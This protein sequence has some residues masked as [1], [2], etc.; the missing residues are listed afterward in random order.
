MLRSGQSLLVHASAQ[1]GDVVVAV[2]PAQAGWEHL[3]FEARRLERGQRWGRATAESELG[4]V[5]LGGTCTIESNHG[6]WPAVGARADVFAGLPHA[7]YLPRGSE[8]AIT[9]R[10]P[11]E[12]GY[13]WCAAERTFPARLIEP[14]EIRVEIR[15]GDNMTRQINSIIPPGFPCDR[16]VL[17]EVYTPGGNWSSFP[18]HKHDRHHV[19]AGGIV[20]EADLEEVYFYRFDRPGGFAYQR[21]YTSDRSTDALLLCQD[22]DLVLVPHGYHPV[23]AAPGATTYYLNVLAGSAQSLAASDD[24]TY[25]WIKTSYQAVDPRIPI[26]P[27]QTPWISDRHQTA[28]SETVGARDTG[29]QAARLKR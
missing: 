16:L 12:I 6:T 22:G 2:N 18:P 19:D 15:G 29:R 3:S 7:L 21:V 25:G 26:Y 1:P 13:G 27:V 10:S 11:C 24:P 20:V 17:V 5:V 23:V 9:A 4:L 14:E 8:F 28:G